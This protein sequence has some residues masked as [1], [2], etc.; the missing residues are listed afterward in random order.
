MMK[1][2]VSAIDGNFK[3][4]CESIAEFQEKH[5]GEYTALSTRMVSSDGINVI[6]PANQETRDEIEKHLLFEHDQQL[7]QSSDVYTH[8]NAQEY[9]CNAIGISEIDLVFLKYKS[10]SEN[11]DFF[12][13]NEKGRFFIAY[14]EEGEGSINDLI[15]NVM[16][17]NS[18]NSIG[19]GSIGKKDVSLI[20]LSGTSA[21][22]LDKSSKATCIDDIAS[23]PPVK[24]VAT[25]ISLDGYTGNEDTPGY[26]YRA[27]KLSASGDS[28]FN[29]AL[30]NSFSYYDNIGEMVGFSFRFH[31]SGFCNSEKMPIQLS[32]R[33]FLTY[34]DLADRSKPE[35]V[36]DKTSTNVNDSFGVIRADK[37]TMRKMGCD[38][39]S[40]GIHLMF[41]HYVGD[42]WQSTPAL[43]E[44]NKVYTIE[45]I[46]NFKP[47]SID[48]KTIRSLT[49]EDEKQLDQNFPF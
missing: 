18:K 16:Y 33:G 41:N 19:T 38:D 17:K 31:T 48:P 24:S 2:D 29:E 47:V 5:L 1:F 32:D 22:M 49:K 11:P 12:I 44:K 7:K 25:S 43:L 10:A 20:T 21:L 13:E 36:M 35:T 28:D 30:S 40:D 45:S 37:E 4:E 8:L 23:R 46:T 14:Q 27:F 42:D 6:T 39:N 15:D 26:S 3:I 9:I 34:S